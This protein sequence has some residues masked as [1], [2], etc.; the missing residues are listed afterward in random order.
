VA[1]DPHA[2]YAHAIRTAGLL[3]NAAIVVDHF[4]LVKFANDAVTAVRRRVIWQTAG[5]R[6]RRSDPPWA[7]RRRLLTAHE[8]LSET[9]FARMWNGCL[10]GDPTGEVL[11]AYIAKE[12]LRALLALARTGATRRETSSRLEDF[13]RWCAD[14]TIPS[15]TPSPPPSR[16]GGQR[17]SRSSTPASPTP[18]PK[19]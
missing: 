8:R 3:P 13:Y 6:G 5:R 12:K 14:S 7:N 15:C 11:T 17:S 4:H 16:P 9:G 19:G 10:D 2:G 18:A 1:I